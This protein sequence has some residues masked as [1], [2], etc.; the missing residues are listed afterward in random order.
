ML[1]YSIS[2]FEEATSKIGNKSVIPRTP[3]NS[4]LKFTHKF[5]ITAVY[6]GEKGKVYAGDVNWRHSAKG[7]QVTEKWEPQ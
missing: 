5:K 2:C 4:I 6:Y 3:K 1:L 7:L